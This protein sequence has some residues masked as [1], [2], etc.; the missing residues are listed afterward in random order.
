MPT[1]AHGETGTRI[2]SPGLFVTE[3]IGIRPL[4]RLCE[5]YPKVRVRAEPSKTYEISVPLRPPVL[6]RRGGLRGGG[7][8]RPSVSGS[9]LGCGAALAILAP[10]LLRRPSFRTARSPQRPVRDQ[11]NERSLHFG[12]RE[13]SAS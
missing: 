12:V 5:I 4:R 2:Y 3:A 11:R 1:V 6:R 7:G 9:L 13:F 10:R 8:A